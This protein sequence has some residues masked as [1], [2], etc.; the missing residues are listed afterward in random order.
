MVGIQLN[1]TKIPKLEF[2][3]VSKFVLNST[4]FK[5]YDKIYK[6]TF[7]FCGTPLSP[8]IADLR[9]LESYIL[10]N[11]LSHYFTS[12]MWMILP[13]LLHTLLNELLKKF[14]SFHLRLK[15]TI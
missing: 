11:L 12:D 4:F 14:N 8:I 1:H 13:Y 2:F 9:N 7:G 10:K 6:Q 3:N 15:F 5:F